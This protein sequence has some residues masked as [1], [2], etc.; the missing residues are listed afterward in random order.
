VIVVADTITA[1]SVSAVA[2]FRVV[3]AILVAVVVRVV[4]VVVILAT[5]PAIAEPLTRLVVVDAAVAAPLQ[6]VRPDVI[7]VARNA[8]VVVRA[9]RVARRR[10]QER[11]EAAHHEPACPPRASRPRHREAA[12]A[13]QHCLRLVH[14]ASPWFASSRFE[15]KWDYYPFHRSK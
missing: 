7:R 5:A 8:R 12:L 6:A 1:A 9:P 13:H 2:V 4:I 3:A 14:L 10:D 11:R 15:F